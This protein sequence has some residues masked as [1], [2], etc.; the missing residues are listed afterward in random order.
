MNLWAHFGARNCLAAAAFEKGRH[1]MPDVAVQMQVRSLD[2]LDIFLPSEIE[3]L[4]NCL[5]NLPQREL[6]AI[7]DG[8]TSQSNRLEA[9]A[10]PGGYARLLGCYT[11]VSSPMI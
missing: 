7:V 11:P 8:H 2:C 5:I 1:E 3:A 10:R 4:A 9:N 6:L